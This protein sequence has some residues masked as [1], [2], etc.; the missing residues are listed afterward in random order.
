MKFTYKMGE[1]EAAEAAEAAAKAGVGSR[2]A[3]ALGAGFPV[4]GG[5]RRR[6]LA[7]L[8]HRAEL[9][10]LWEP[11]GGGELQMVGRCES[12]GSGQGMRE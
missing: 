4:P 5:R 1:R 8:A 7:V 2:V 3:V 9:D 12:G 6:R 11:R 10:G